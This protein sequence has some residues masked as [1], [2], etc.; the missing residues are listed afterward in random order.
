MEK[1]SARERR[2]KQERER[3]RERRAASVRAENPHRAPALPQ[4]H[5]LSS[6]RRLAGGAAAARRR[7]FAR[8]GG[9]KHAHYVAAAARR[10]FARGER[11]REWRADRETDAPISRRRCVSVEART[12]DNEDIAAAGLF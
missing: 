6:T 8:W 5:Y 9:K 1:E 4:P 7:R 11:E 10:E 3:E 2:T 12:V